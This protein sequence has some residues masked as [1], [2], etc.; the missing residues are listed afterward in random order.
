[1]TFKQKK[2]QDVRINVGINMDKELPKELKVWLDKNPRMAA[3]YYY[4]GLLVEEGMDINST[5][6]IRMIQR[7]FEKDLET[8]IQYIRKITTL[9]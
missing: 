3:V 4:A 1:M 8:L 2:Q 7:T 5:E 9:N 6:G